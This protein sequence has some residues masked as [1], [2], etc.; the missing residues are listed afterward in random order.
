MFVRATT[1]D[2][3]QLVSEFSRLNGL[4]NYSRDVFSGR[5]PF[6]L[7]TVVAQRHEHSGEKVL[8][9]TRTLIPGSEI[10]R[11]EEVEPIDPSNFAVEDPSTFRPVVLM[12]RGE[13]G[14]WKAEGD[15]L[16]EGAVAGAE[17]P[18]HRESI[19]YGFYRYVILTAAVEGEGGVE[20]VAEVRHWLDEIPEHL[21]RAAQPAPAAPVLAVAAD[22]ETSGDGTGE[23]LPDILPGDGEEW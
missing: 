9:R 6:N 23:A 8:H 11:L 10:T 5:K 22:G 19:G 1:R 2:G 14:I 4:E 12:Q 13:A 21:L 16:P 7:W 15:D 20:P 17:Y 3:A 18:I